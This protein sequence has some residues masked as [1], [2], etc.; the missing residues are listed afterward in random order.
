MIKTI[1]NL[2][3]AKD[4]VKHYYNK[5]VDVKVNLGRNK[6]AKYSG[7]LSGMYPA[8]FTVQPFEKGYL[9]KTAYSYSELLCGSVQLSDCKVVNKE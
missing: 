2:Q 9:G 6:I 3:T 1:K 5:Q 7:V 8:L 4:E